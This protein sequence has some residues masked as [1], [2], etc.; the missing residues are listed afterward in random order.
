M[1]GDYLT[2]A[3]FFGLGIVFVAATLAL[4]FVLHPSK[5]T[6]AKL[7]PYECGS[8]P[9]GP[10]WIQYRIGYYVYALLFLIFD[11]E[12]VFLFPWAVVFGQLGA[13]VLFEMVVFIGILG[14]G[15]AY[16]W[17]EGALQWR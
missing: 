15:L 10:P 2:V 17:K 11:I 8:E 3:V 9:I 6:A 4:S 13:V 7:A 16:A 12:T 1:F 14:I 5:R